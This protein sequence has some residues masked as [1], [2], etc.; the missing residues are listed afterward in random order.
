MFYFL[1]HLYL[2]VLRHQRGVLQCIWHS[3]HT[4]RIKNK[5]LHLNFKNYFRKHRARHMQCL[6]TLSIPEHAAFCICQYS[7]L[8]VLDY[9]Q[10]I[11]EEI[12]KNYTAEKRKCEKII[13][14]TV[15][16]KEKFPHMYKK[17]SFITN[18]SA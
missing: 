4:E 8:G 17:K 6:Q 18:W 3:C 12:R 15:C 2:L 16:L 14:K 11:K 10:S 5:S 13:S 9:C 7:R 1:H